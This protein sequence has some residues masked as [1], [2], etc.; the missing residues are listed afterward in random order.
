MKEKLPIIFKP[1]DY[2]K[3]GSHPIIRCLID[4]EVW[5]HSYPQFLCS[6]NYVPEITFAWDG[7][8]PKQVTIDTI[9]TIRKIYSPSRLIVVTGFHAHGI[10]VVSI[11]QFRF[12]CELVS[13]EEK[14]PHHIYTFKIL[15][16]I[17]QT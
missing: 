1:W 11:S 17:T 9:R 15:R 5:G 6:D 7:E 12:E 14:P 4:S 10:G 16:E 3:L 8:T 13:H 2:L